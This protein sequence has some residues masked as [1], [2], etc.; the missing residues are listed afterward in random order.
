M[1]EIGCSNCPYSKP[2]SFNECFFA[3]TGEAKKCKAYINEKGAENG[4]TDKNEG[5]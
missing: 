1:N 4:N 5:N 2:N 3:N